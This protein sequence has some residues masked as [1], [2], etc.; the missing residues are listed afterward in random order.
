M[1]STPLID[2]R[3][4]FGVTFGIAFLSLQL[5]GR[6]SLGIQIGHRHR[7]PLGIRWYGRHRCQF[8]NRQRRSGMIGGR[9]LHFRLSRAG[10]SHGDLRNPFAGHEQQKDERPH[11]TDENRQ[12]RKQ[13]N[14]RMRRTMATHR[15][16]VSIQPEDGVTVRYN[17]HNPSGRW[18]LS[19]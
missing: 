6:Q 17:R 5:G 8:G 16:G 3:D 15:R 11:H 12:E 1:R 19:G 14:R 7:R 18:S 4:P 9:C 10:A 13:L 2:Q